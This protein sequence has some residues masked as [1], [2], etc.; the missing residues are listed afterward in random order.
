MLKYDSLTLK[1]FV[2]ENEDF[3]TG[4]RIQKI[5]QPTRRDFIFSLRSAGETRKLYV[6][7]NPQFFHVCFM[8]LENEARRGIEIPKKPPMFCMLLRKY[9]EGTRIARVNQPEGER[10]L[11]FYTETY[12]EAGEKIDLCLAIELMGKHSNVI[13]YN[14]DTNVIIGAAHN[15]GPE[16][17]AEREIAGG[18]PYTYP[19]KPLQAV[20]YRSLAKEGI[21]VDDYYARAVEEYRNDKL[22]ADTQR[23]LKKTSAALEKMQ[24]QLEKEADYDK[25]RLWGDLIMSSLYA[26]KDFS[27][28]IEV[29][30]TVIQLDPKLTLKENANRYYKLYNKSKKSVEKL[31]MLIAEYEKEI[32]AVILPLTP[33]RQID[34]CSHL[35]EREIYGC[36]VFVGRNNKQND[37]IVSK[38]AKDEDYWFHVKDC[39]GSHVLLKC[40]NPSDALILECAKLAKE[41]STCKDSKTG[42]IY[43]KRKFLKKPPGAKPGY[44]IYKNEK[45]III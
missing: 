24:K 34:L 45:E 43:T 17:S 27:E 32:A 9:L 14:Y 25:Y 38:L 8:S 42:V 30:D 37:Y 40:K 4:A 12:N 35:G 16:K 22:L 28:Q 15:V 29:F 7:I 18:L 41:H 13:L 3:L 39:P 19:P 20:Q 11:E 21:N 1:A 44:V 26:N 2:E 31:S 36:K 33:A 10:I 5:Q 23:T 6:N